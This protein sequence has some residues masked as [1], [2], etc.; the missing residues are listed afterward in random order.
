MAIA[1]IR[2]LGRRFR[3]WLGNT[4]LVVLV[5]V[6]LAVGAIWSFIEIA[7]EVVEGETQR[8]DESIVLALREHADPSDPIGPGWFEEA[9]RDYTALGGY[10]VLGLLTVIVSIFLLMNGK[11]HAM[12]LVLIATIGGML[13]SDLLK[14][15][16]D[17]P[18]PTI[19]PHLSHAGSSSFPSGHSM[20]SAVVYL[21]LGSL[22]DRLVEKRRLRLFILCVA[23]LL[24]CLVGCS[25]VYLGVHYPTDVLAGWT[26]GL[27]WAILCW[28]VARWLQRRGVVEKPMEE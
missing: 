6:F 10:A 8:I 12:W 25:R 24:T 13:L 1:D 11:S 15:F 23:M 28:L 3:E 5:A 21:T 22:L 26:V 2:A 4:D 19:V 14:A 16:F 20:L 9:V 18:R 27:A 17:R 7:D